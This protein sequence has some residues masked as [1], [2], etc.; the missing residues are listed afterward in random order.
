MMLLMVFL[1]VGMRASHSEKRISQLYSN[2]SLYIRVDSVVPLASTFDHN[3][4][5]MNKEE[6]SSVRITKEEI[7][8][9]YPEISFKDQYFV[10][11]FGF[12]MGPVS[13]RV[14]QVIITLDIVYLYRVDAPNSKLELSRVDKWKVNSTLN[15]QSGRTLIANATTPGIKVGPQTMEFI[16][17]T[18]QQ[19][20]VNEQ[21]NILQI[22]CK[23]DDQDNCTLSAIVKTPVIPMFFVNT[24]NSSD[25]RQ[26]GSSLKLLKR[27]Y[28]VDPSCQYYFARYC[29]L[30]QLQFDLQNNYSNSMQLLAKNLSNQIAQI[31]VMNT[32]KLMDG[33]VEVPLQL[34]EIE[35]FNSYFLFFNLKMTYRSRVGGIL[36]LQNVLQWFDFGYDFRTGLVQCQ[37]NSPSALSCYLQLYILPAV[38]EKTENTFKSR[39]LSDTQNSSRIDQPI[40]GIAYFT[41]FIDW[42][43]TLVRIPPINLPMILPEDKIA[44]INL[45]FIV[46]MDSKHESND[47]TRLKIFQRGT[48]NDLGEIDAQG[49]VIIMKSLGENIMLYK[50]SDIGLVFK[51]KPNKSSGFSFSVA[52][53]TAQLPYFKIETGSTNK[54]HQCFDYLKGCQH[55]EFNFSYR[56]SLKDREYPSSPYLPSQSYKILEGY[57]VDT[58]FTSVLP[59]ETNKIYE[60]PIWRD[61]VF[62]NITDMFFGLPLN[63]YSRADK[64]MPERGIPKLN[65]SE[66]EACFS[67]LNLSIT[68][69]Q[70]GNSEKLTTW[71][72]E[73]YVIRR[74]DGSIV[75][76]FR[77]TQGYFSSM[78]DRFYYL[79]DP[80]D[81]K[82]DS[83][84]IFSSKNLMMFELTLLEYDSVQI[85]DD[86]SVD[87]FYYVNWPFNIPAGL[88]GYIAVV[89][90]QVAEDPNRINP[91]RF[92][93]IE[94]EDVPVIGHARVFVHRSADSMRDDLMIMRNTSQADFYLIS[95]DLKQQNQSRLSFSKIM[96]FNLKNETF[97]WPW[98]KPRSIIDVFLADFNCLYIRAYYMLPGNILAEVMLIYQCDFTMNNAS[99]F[100]YTYVYLEN[101]LVIIDDLLFNFAVLN[102]DTLDLDYYR[103]TD[104][105]REFVKLVKTKLKPS[106]QINLKE[107]MHDPSLRLT[108]NGPSVLFMHANRRQFFLTVTSNLTANKG[109]LLF[110]LD[111]QMAPIKFVGHPKI[112]DFSTIKVRNP[113]PY[114]FPMAFR[115]IENIEVLEIIQLNTDNGLCIKSPLYKVDGEDN[116]FETDAFT[117]VLTGTGKNDFIQ[118][119]KGVSKYNFDI[120]KTEKVISKGY[121]ALA[122]DLFTGLVL[123]MGI[124]CPQQNDSRF[125][126]RRDLNLQINCQSESGHADQFTLTPYIQKDLDLF[127]PSVNSLS[128]QGTSDNENSWRMEESLLSEPHIG[129]ISAGFRFGRNSP[130]MLVFHQR[131]SIIK[132]G[133]FSKIIAF[134]KLYDDVIK[135]EINYTLCTNIC[136]MTHVNDIISLE[137]VCKNGLL[138]KIYNFSLDI[139]KLAGIDP[140]TPVTIKL[141]ATG[142]TVFNMLVEQITQKPI[143]VRYMGR[144]LFILDNVVL[145][146]YNNRPFLNIYQVQSSA[147]NG[148]RSK[149]ALTVWSSLSMEEFSNA[150]IVDFS[151]RRVSADT[152]R[153]RHYSM[154]IVVQL[155]ADNITSYYFNEIKVYCK[156]EKDE[157]PV[158]KLSQQKYLSL[159]SI[160]R[161]THYTE[162]PT[163]YIYGFTDDEIFEWESLGPGLDF[164]QVATYKYLLVCDPMKPIDVI[165]L[166]PFMALYCYNTSSDLS[167]DLVLLFSTDINMKD[168]AFYPIQQLNMP[169]VDFPANMMLACY[170]AP[171]GV[172]LLISNSRTFLTQ[173]NL[174]KQA[175]I[176]WT[177]RSLTGEENIRL[178]VF[179]ENILTKQ[180]SEIVFTVKFSDILT[181]YLRTEENSLILLIIFAIYLIVLG[182]FFRLHIKKTTGRELAKENFVI[183]YRRLM[184]EGV[185]I[186]VQTTAMILGTPLGD[187]TLPA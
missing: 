3:L 159:D 113:A 91:F 26:C 79:L 50:H 125:A 75:F 40:V 54:S 131:I 85:V 146:N 4:T 30:S 32:V 31:G 117:T 166:E 157:V 141:D 68:N 64:Y 123:N 119:F 7:Y 183:E 170:Q 105:R 57:L 47:T 8:K 95:Y 164:N 22:S 112:G 121:K 44:A 58:N 182:Y 177:Q 106:G 46:F 28:G 98:G 5:L 38:N 60:I 90:T 129:N 142:F 16:L 23:D 184:H 9:E 101:S 130:Y 45:N 152:D 73:P 153:L 2:S 86:T 42:Q 115:Y 13:Q 174:N 144:L 43:G 35:E 149:D 96:S 100:F 33:T 77:V 55:L 14:Y 76:S 89:E 143:K 10:D 103:M 82:I 15:S 59:R 185:E 178:G 107:I 147:N 18:I 156:N 138:H 49:R 148:T 87:A 169:D 139:N 37:Q 167:D 102:F 72:F 66:N 187:T 179:T 56:V 1:C 155:K 137:L 171:S 154:T 151:L 34:A 111:V 84:I 17:L 136:E 70:L 145:E 109:F 29:K 69:Y 163:T 180:T 140:S 162:E 52:I 36:V 74:A 108:R 93:F 20:T 83:E 161:L 128:S 41:E 175:S 51:D 118:I 172:K 97:S 88:T 27:R 124:Y 12:R 160:K 63:F 21:I 48:S 78:S 80:I 116:T 53:Y 176:E 65:L 114:Q 133:D 39:I 104:F 158:F 181:S 126:V 99:C 94:P 24:S 135:S 132:M 61:T 186:P 168:N 25:L 165:K 134:V 6:A 19:G 62:F 150:N 127:Y 120:E 92:W 11:S 173:Y 67:N 81:T 71:S 110:N 122:S